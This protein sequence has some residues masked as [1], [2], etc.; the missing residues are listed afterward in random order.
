MSNTQ[1]SGFFDCRRPNVLRMRLHALCPT[2]QFITPSMFYL[3]K[4][5]LLPNL[6]Y[7]RLIYLHSLLLVSISAFKISKS[8]IRSFALPLLNRCFLR[9][10]LCVIYSD[11]NIQH[12]RV[13]SLLCVR[14]C[15][16]GWV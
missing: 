4:L 2:V 5:I 1:V 7:M 9:F 16:H 3:Q 14:V 13:Y 10:V 8:L 6:T 12:C 15:I 11:A